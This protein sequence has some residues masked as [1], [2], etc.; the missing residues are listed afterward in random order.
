MAHC[1]RKY[2]SWVYNSTFGTF[3]VDDESFA[4]RIVTGAEG[5]LF[6]NKMSKNA[7]QALKKPSSSEEAVKSL[8]V[9]AK[10]NGKPAEEAVYNDLDI[11]ETRGLSEDQINILMQDRDKWR[12]FIL[13]RRARECLLDWAGAR[14]LVQA[15]IL[16]FK[17]ALLAK[18]ELENCRLDSIESWR[19]VDGEFTDPDLI[20]T[21]NALRKRA[22][23]Q[24][25]FCN[26]SF[27]GYDHRFQL[28]TLGGTIAV[29]E[30]PLLCYEEPV[31]SEELV[32]LVEHEL[33][34]KKRDKSEGGN[35]VQDVM[36]REKESFVAELNSAIQVMHEY[37]AKSAF[38]VKQD[39]GF[40]AFEFRKIHSLGDAL[41]D[42]NATVL[43]QTRGK[44]ALSKFKIK[45][46]FSSKIYGFHRALNVVQAFRAATQIA[47]AQRVTKLSKEIEA[48]KKG[49]DANA[50]VAPAVD[51]SKMPRNHLH[52]L[53]A[54]SDPLYEFRKRCS[55][56]P[57]NL[58]RGS[59]QFYGCHQNEKR[60]TLIDGKDVELP[61]AVS[62]KDADMHGHSALFRVTYSEWTDL[63][64]VRKFASYSHG[65]GARCQFRTKRDAHKAAIKFLEENI[66]EIGRHK[67]SKR[68]CDQHF[69]AIE[70][71]EGPRP[72]R[73]GK[74]EQR[75]VIRRYIEQANPDLVLNQRR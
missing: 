62:W 25:R 73:Y 64:W 36:R 35:S 23:I 10:T 59:R 69:D 52:E 38:L 57:R 31:P 4:I 65:A 50:P 60:T 67:A 15:D 11:G 33:K 49:D 19:G 63:K 14:N 21:G 27:P 75:G 32:T 68:L 48:L 6:R 70:A 17:W 12:I 72:L 24:C 28:S 56:D 29:G 18:F 41:L 30:T 46:G 2:E 3:A 1:A 7:L 5:G 39:K 61:Q 58:L 13:E 40:S 34:C 71:D 47:E 43:D 26:K 44:L 42:L 45:D 74:P 20:K 53:A 55:N 9:S 8:V 16:M 22:K 51:L 37:C 66:D 54:A